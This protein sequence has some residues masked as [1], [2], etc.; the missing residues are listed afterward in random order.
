MSSS[1][2]RKVIVTCAVT[3]GGEI[4]PN[5]R[6]VPITPAQIADEAIAAAKAGAA[7][8]HIHVRDPETGK[9]SM[10]QALYA[11]VV[12]RI[13]DSGQDVL[14]NLTTGVGARYEPGLE[15]GAPPI[16][17]VMSPDERVRHVV[18][19]RPE[20]CTLDVATMSFGP[21][22]I[23]NTPAHLRA[24]GQAIREAGVKPELEVFDL[25]HAEL[26]AR[27]VAKGELPAPPFYQFVLG[28]PGGAPATPQGMIMMRS[29]LPE[30]AIWSAF[31][32]GRAQM[33]M[34]AQSVILGGHCRVGLEDNL[35][36][37]RGVLAEG[38]APLV[39]RAATIIRSLG[40]DLATPAEA[41]DMLSIDAAQAGALEPA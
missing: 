30:D 14:I 19:L 1:G 37:E 7:S 41:R 36:L 34:V 22:T 28:I 24:M 31:G 29:M 12:S 2:K 40:C 6:Y 21:N 3:G 26:A 8:V 27:M 35:Y 18:N 10:E 13:R 15:P 11:E 25:G 39:E 4:G 33:P 38:N 32:I 23:V 5:S 20:I 17:S 9:T 16:T